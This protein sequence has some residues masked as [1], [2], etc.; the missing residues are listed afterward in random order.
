MRNP[1]VPPVYLWGSGAPAPAI[2]ESSRC[3]CRGGACPL[4]LR[5]VRFRFPIASCSIVSLPVRKRIRLQEAVYQ[6]PGTVYSITIATRRRNPVFIDL[7]FSKACLAI[8]KEM[9]VYSEVRVFAYCMMPDHIHLLL[10]TSAEGSIVPFLG[11]WK[12]RCYRE[13]RRLGLSRRFWQ[14]SF[15]DHI[16]RSDEDL[17]RAAQY[18]LEN[19]VRAGLVRD[20][21]DYPLSGSFEWDI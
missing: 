17:R 16:L 13:R 6:N 15:Y 14:R 7:P 21:G 8:L 12:S 11:S 5:P 3:K 10:G 18:I 4:P 19:P 2:S 9:S 20:V 1:V